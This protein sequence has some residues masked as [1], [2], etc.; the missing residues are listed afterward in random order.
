MI[1]REMRYA[2]VDLANQT[3]DVK[4]V[5]ADKFGTWGLFLQE[6]RFWWQ[7]DPTMVVLTTGILTG[8]GAPGT[9]AMT[10][11]LSW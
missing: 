8:T 6:L 1:Q 4:D 10:W 3:W 2:L 9:G 5:L 7:I 11:V